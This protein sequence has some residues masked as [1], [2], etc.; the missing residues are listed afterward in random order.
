MTAVGTPSIML[1]ESVSI[2]SLGSGIMIGETL[3]AAQ[4]I[5]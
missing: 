1:I 2:M 5:R 4:S 3:S